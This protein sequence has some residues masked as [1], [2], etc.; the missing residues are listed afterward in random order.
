MASND[1]KENRLQELGGSDYEIADNEPDI[2]G[3]TVKDGSGQKIGKVDEL[4]FDIQSQK[5]RYLVVSL[6]EKT[7]QI[8][9]HDVLVPIGLAELNDKDNDVFLPSITM[10]QLRSL[11]EYEKG[12]ID[13]S[14]ENKIRSILTG[15]EGALGTTALASSRGNEDF[16]DHEHFNEENIYRNRSQTDK[17][18]ISI[19]VVE[20]NVQVGKKEV[21]TGGIRLRS[22]IVEED[23]TENLK[24]RDEKVRVERTPVN[25]PANEGDLKEENIEMT[26]RTE[27]PVVSKE[28]RVV[29]E[30]RLNKEV[31]QRDETIK[32]TVRKTKVD[33]ENIEG[34]ER[35]Y[36]D[37]KTKK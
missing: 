36:K 7:L 27:V 24:L 31:E 32:E 2:K 18:Q 29:E 35:Q 16:Y 25:R 23:V 21:E 15:S 11:P 8:K 4:I 1:Y 20:E 33:V 30:V 13:S 10:E 22:K 5:V 12:K 3:W 37:E 26:E 6:K 34:K 9:D 19:P 14:M 17:D 28:A